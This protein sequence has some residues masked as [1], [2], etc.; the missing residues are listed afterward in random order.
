VNKS[1]AYKK[2]TFTN[3]EYHYIGVPAN[4]AL[5]KKNGKGK[6]FIDHCLLENP[7]VLASNDK[8]Q[9]AKTKEH[10]CYRP[11]HEQRNIQR[12][13]NRRVVLR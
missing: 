8:K 9:D 12:F 5:R 11:L 1:K 10:R 4:L 2:E 6:D 3:Y 13:K 7:E